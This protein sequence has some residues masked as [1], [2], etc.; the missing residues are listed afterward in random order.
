MTAA[1]PKTSNPANTSAPTPWFADKIR[2]QTVVDGL[3]TGN[4]WSASGQIIDRLAFVACS[5]NAGLGARTNAQVEALAVNAATK[6]TD[7]TASG[8]STMGEKLVARPGA[9]IVVSIV[10]RDPAGT[11][12]SPYTFN[13]PSLA[14]VGVAQPLNMPV[15][16][17]MNG[18]ATPTG[19]ALTARPLVCRW[20]PLLPRTPR[21]L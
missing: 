6:N 3:R 21:L 7:I 17:H 19:C 14:Q 5:S 13:N 1:R 9:D 10:V 11:N 12:N 16:D 20:C 18:L 8:C 2:P 4:S 15:L